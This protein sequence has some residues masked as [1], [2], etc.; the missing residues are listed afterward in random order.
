MWLVD[1]NGN[2]VTTA[3]GGH[4]DYTSGA[5]GYWLDPDCNITNWSNDGYPANLM[6]LE[7]GG[8]GV[9]NLG[10][11][12]NSTPAGTQATVRFDFVSIDDPT[13]FLQFI[14]AVTFD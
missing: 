11:S 5:L 7:Y 1:A 2:R 12:K 4:P 9:Y 8:N 3:D 13:C 14:V 6:F 10:N